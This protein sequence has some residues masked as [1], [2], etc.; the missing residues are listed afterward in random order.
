M[1][2]PPREPG[3]SQA[4]AAT[5]SVGGVEGRWRRWVRHRPEVAG[6][7]VMMTFSLVLLVVL[8]VRAPDS[9]RGA[10][11]AATARA[12][13]LGDGRTTVV[14]APDGFRLTLP[15]GWRQVRLNPSTLEQWANS[16]QARSIVE[17]LGFG[18]PE[19]A[20]S[21]GGVLLTATFPGAG[22]NGERGAFAV[23]GSTQ[24]ITADD[25][26][27]AV[28]ERLLTSSAAVTQVTVGTQMLGSGPVLHASCQLSADP[29]GAPSTPAMFFD[30]YLVPS[31]RHGGFVLMFAA[32]RAGTVQSDAIDILESFDPEYPG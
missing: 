13:P 1:P 32:T 8:A 4:G 22:G 24:P 29:T 2:V 14:D 26:S 17:R 5:A 7:V 16:G 10:S 25:A 18:S 15:A 31:S 19:L 27:A 28:L 20:A 23:T 6:L 9:D 11:S 12:V 30:L 3:L 21:G